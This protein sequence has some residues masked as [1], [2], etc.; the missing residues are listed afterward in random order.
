[1][2]QKNGRLEGVRG[3]PFSYTE[4]KIVAIKNYEALLKDAIKRVKNLESSNFWC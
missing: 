4:R 2:V 3:S 1:M